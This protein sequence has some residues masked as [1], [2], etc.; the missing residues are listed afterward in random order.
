MMKTI[1]SLMMAL[2]LSVGAAM[3]QKVAYV[4]TK[5]IMEQIPDYQTAQEEV[6]RISQKWQQELEQMYQEIERLYREFQTQEVLLPEDVKR[7][8]QEEIFAK[9]REAKEFREKKFGYNGELFT[10][11][12]TKVR[13]IQDK[14]FKSIEA[15][16]KRRRFDIVL[17][18]AGEVTLVYTN[19]QYDLS[20]LVL[21]DMGIDMEGEGE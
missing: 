8:R 3:A 19:A 4:D 1:L 2:F 6:D 13:P 9:E 21:E 15:V 20:D 11:Q 17:D 12:D 14:V 16:A 10:L 5:Y 7:E 18:K